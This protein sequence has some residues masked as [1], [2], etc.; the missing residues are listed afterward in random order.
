MLKLPSEVNQIINKFKDSGYQV[1]LVGGTVKYLLLNKPLLQM[2]DWDFTTNAKPEEIQKLF[3][4]SFY[5]NTY[6]TVSV[7]IEAGGRKIIAEI[8][9]F[10]KE[11]S[12]KDKRHPEEIQWATE[13]KEDLSRRDFTINAIA[14][15]GKEFI[16]PFDGIKDLKNK[17]I[18]AVRDP[19]ERFQEDALRLL[20]AVRFAT[21]LNFEIES[22]TKE[23]I[24]KNAHL[25]KNISWERIRDE[26][27]KILASESPDKGIILLKETGLLHYILPELEMCFSIPQKSPNRHHIYDVGTH[28]IMSLRYCP[29]KDVITRFATL[30][31]DL[32]KAKTFRKDEKTGIITFYNH[33]VVGTK[34]ALEIANRFKLS[35]KQKDKLVKLVKY[36]QFTV[37]ENQTDKAIR[38]FLRNV[39]KEY[40]QDIFDLRT[41]DRLGSGVK[42]TSWR[43][44]L[45]KKRV[46]QLLKKPFTIT[47]LKINGNDVMQTLNIKPGPRVGKIL[48][49]IFNLVVEGK[50][51]NEKEELI[52]Y[53]KNKYSK[54]AK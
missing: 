4:N 2:D 14:F 52:N 32:G 19:E 24:K 47:D 40:L 29:S 54:T 3:P 43:T 51:K 1:Y 36:H 30:I 45:F 23:A 18:R 39:G 53:I 38:R 10:R 20:R 25:I 37:S 49:D 5:H 15:D 42:A 31:H 6:G 26:F 12:Y 8:T 21:Q 35:N 33:E 11:G 22:K 16:D 41:G 9:S 48:Q 44:E 27:L 50:L 34:I 13:L 7:P 46:K 17:L 28:S